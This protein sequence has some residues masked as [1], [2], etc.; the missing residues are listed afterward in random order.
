MKKI[1]LILILAASL[2]SFAFGAKKAK[3]PK[4]KVVIVGTEGAYP[5]YNFVNT[6]GEADGYDIDSVSSELQT[7]IVNYLRSL[8]MDS[9]SNNAP[10][11]RYNQISSIIM[12]SDGVLDHQNLLIN[13]GTANLQPSY[14]Q[15]ATLTEMGVTN[16]PFITAQPSNY[17]TVVDGTARFSVTASGSDL[18]YRWQWAA[19][20]SSTWADSDLSGSSSANLNFTVPSADFNG[21]RYRCVVTSAGTNSVISTEATLTVSS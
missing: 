17:A 1:R 11:I 7:E 14:D 9:T 6:K 4:E 8:T 15:A 19:S 12:D 5:P 3:A 20:G 16:G 21:R 10:I 13:G 2:S 18:T